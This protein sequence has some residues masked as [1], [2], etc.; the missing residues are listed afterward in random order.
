[1]AVSLM[2]DFSVST[3]SMTYAGQSH[4]Y[5]SQMQKDSVIEMDTVSANSSPLIASLQEIHAKYANNFSGKVATYIPELAKA[6]PKL[7]GIA[8]VT[9]DGFSYEVGDASHPFTIQSISKPFVYGLALEDHGADYVLT[10]VGVEPTGEAFNSIVFDER[11]NR[12]FNPM[13]NAGAIATTALIEGESPERR[14]E[15]VLKKFTDLADRCLTIDHDVYLSESKTGHRNRAIGY[16]ELSTGMIDGQVDEHLDLYFKQCS[17]LASARD[18]AVMAA[19][20]ANDGVNPLSGKRALQAAYVKNVLSVMHSCGMYD[21]TGEWTYRIGLPAKS[22]VSGGVIAV[23][24]GQ[25]GIGIFSPLLDAQGNSCRGIQVCEELSARFKLHMFGART[26]TG[27]CLRRCY[28]ATSVR[29]IRQRGRGEQAILDRKGQRICVYE[30]QGSLF[31]GAL[32]QVF[33]KLSAD[34][35]TLEYLILDVRRVMGIDECALTLVVQLNVW[36]AT[37]GKKLI[38]A[39][40]APRF[41]DTLKRSPDYVWTDKSFF[42]DTDTALEWCENRLLAQTQTRPVGETLRVPLSA[43]NI[44]GG[45]TAQEIVLLESIVE[46]VYY[47]QGETIIRENDRADDLFLLAAGTVSVYLRLNDGPRRQRV[48]TITPGLA[49]GELALLDGGKR[50]ADVIADEPALCYVL[51]I[52]KLRALASDHPAVESKLIFNISRELSARLRR[53]DAEI[54]SLAE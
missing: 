33:R 16:L 52:V 26:T 10:K 41:A 23:L 50:S 39:H 7:F 11:N 24:P 31:F 2:R 9:A 17:I 22:G 29:S 1:M 37:Q 13:V 4:F 5:Q 21:Y 35:A 6:N 53:A 14:I 45:F 20:L 42:S 40:L 27:V 25:F 46:E 19:T 38:F 18:L 34:L 36:L 51:P 3:E 32:E 12:P 28:R 44:L 48:S 49:F 8:L 47:A 15:R 43:M 30:L 54:R